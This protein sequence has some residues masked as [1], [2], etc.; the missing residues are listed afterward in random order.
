MAPISPRLLDLLAT[1]I[2][3]RKQLAGCGLI[4]CL[5]L[6]LLIGWQIIDL[7]LHT[8]GAAIQVNL[9]L[10]AA[11]ALF[12]LFC[13][14]MFWPVRNVENAPFLRMLRERQAE[15]RAIWTYGKRQIVKGPRRGEWMKALVI[16]LADG[17]KHEMEL[18]AIDDEE[19]LLRLLSAHAPQARIGPEVPAIEGR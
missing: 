3:V 17:R 11:C 2:R 5:V 6:C 15:I 4:F 18:P 14:W 10:L 7:L 12:G 16:E 19:E 13:F 1:Q 9:I 8:S